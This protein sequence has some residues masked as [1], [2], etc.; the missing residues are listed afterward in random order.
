MITKFNKKS[1]YVEIIPVQLAKKEA[2]IEVAQSANNSIQHGQVVSEG[3]H[4]G[5]VVIFRRGATE[6][7][8]YNGTK[9]YFIPLA[10]ILTEVLLD[11]TYQV[12][13]L[14]EVVENWNMDKTVYGV[15]NYEDVI[16]YRWN[17]D[18]G[19]SKLYFT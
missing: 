11:D 1:G 17:K 13:A 16:K 10:S 3:E 5:K 8:K 2:L 6:E 9:M 15:D 19:K 7:H 18:H 14:R 4:K 12:E